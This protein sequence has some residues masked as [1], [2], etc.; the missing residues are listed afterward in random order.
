MSNLIQTVTSPSLAISDGTIAKAF[1]DNGVHTLTAIE[2]RNFYRWQ[3][4]RLGLDPYSFPMDYLET[5]DG[6]LVL[7]PNQKATDQL[8][9]HRGLS[10]KVV[11][12]ELTEDLAIVVAE[13]IDRQGRTTQAI[14][15]AELTDKFGKP[16]TGQLKAQA[17]MK[18]DTR[19]RRRATLAACGLD[20]EDEG[21]LFDAQV[22]DPP[23]D[24]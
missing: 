24:A 7:Y 12:R 4:D 14:G 13:C 20:S 22:Y 15:T 16:L 23:P 6:R 10:V 3:C 9:K 21:R 19:A 1:K 8:R 11:S 5:R 17:V 2:R 18:A